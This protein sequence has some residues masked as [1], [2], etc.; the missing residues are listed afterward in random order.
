MLVVGRFSGDRL[1]EHGPSTNNEDR[2]RDRW[3][4]GPIQK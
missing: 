2:R 4:N 1:P 3:L